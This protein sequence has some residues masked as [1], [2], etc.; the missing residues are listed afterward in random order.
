M[1]AVLGSITLLVAGL[2]LTN[3]EASFVQ[4]DIEKRLFSDNAF[5]I[6]AIGHETFLLGTLAWCSV[7]NGHSQTLARWWAVGVIP[8]IWNKAISGDQGGATT[9]AIIA[10][11]CLAFGCRKTAWNGPAILLGVLGSLA[12]LVSLPLLTNNEASLI[13]NDL[14]KRLYSDNAFLMRAMGHECFF[15]GTIAWCSVVNGHSQTLARWWAV[16]LIPSVLNKAISGDQ[17]GATTNAVIG[18]ICLG[19]G[20]RK[21]AW[22]G[23]A[24]LI[25]MLGSL[26][27]LVSSL[28]LTNNVE[29]LLTND[30]QKRLVN[31]SAYLVRGLGSELAIIGTLVWCSVANGH[32]AA[33]ARWWAVGAIPSV[34]NKAMSG[35]Q[36]GAMTNAIIGLISLYLGCRASGFTRK[37]GLAASAAKLA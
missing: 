26:S 18:L 15:L 8:S 34:W 35:D 25:G 1:F 10:V 37:A 27:L 21:A 12:L 17:G 20:Y 5:L 31:D 4:N 36:G 24:I 29:P 33:L 9:N 19:F 13:K 22:N 11:I 23:P 3:N 2:L 16:G 28:M 30:I 14:E 32:S 7:V 6:R